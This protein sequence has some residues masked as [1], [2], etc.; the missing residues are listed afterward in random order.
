MRHDDRPTRTT[1]GKPGRSRQVEL[2]LRVTPC[3]ALHAPPDQ[4]TCDSRLKIDCCTTRALRSI[5][6]PRIRGNRLSTGG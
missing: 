4:N 2:A 1:G 6:S 3:M 5:C